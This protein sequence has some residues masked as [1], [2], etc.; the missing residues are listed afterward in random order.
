MPPPAETAT[1]Y[2]VDTDTDRWHVGWDPAVASYYALAE[3]RDGTSGATREDGAGD[4]PPRG[5]P[6]LR[7]LT[8]HLQTEWAYRRPWTSNDQRRRA[9]PT[10]L[11]HYNTQRPHRPRRPGPDHPPVNN[12]TGHYT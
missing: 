8:E 3:P 5:M 6:T 4:E 9:L 10:W 11:R 7:D 12:V 1:R 2:T